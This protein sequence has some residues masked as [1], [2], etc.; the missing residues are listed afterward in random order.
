MLAQMKWLVLS[1]VL[2]GLAVSSGCVIYPR[3][4]DIG[5]FKQEAEKLRPGLDTHEQVLRHLGE[6]TSYSKKRLMYLVCDAPTGVAYFP[7]AP[8]QTGFTTVG[9]TCT[10][11]VLEFDERETLQDYQQKAWVESPQRPEEAA[12]LAAAEQ[13]DQDAQWQLY[14]SAGVLNQNLNWLCQAADAGHAA[15][16]YRV[17]LL[18]RYGWAGER[19]D[20]MLAY[21]WY[22][23]AAT[24]GHPEATAAAKRI[25]SEMKPEERSHAA[26]LLAAWKPG[27]CLEAGPTRD[28]MVFLAEQGDPDMNWALYQ[29][30][31]TLMQPYD[32]QYA[33]AIRWLCGAADAGHLK[34]QRHIGRLY[35]LGFGPLKRDTMRAYYWLRLPA[36]R[37]NDEYSWRRKQL[38]PDQIA[39]AERLTEE[40]QPGQC[41]QEL[42]DAL[43]PVE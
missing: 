5:E 3:A 15:A 36:S 6:P 2:A 28:H 26:D 42:A 22:M 18:Y 37:G 11:F 19:R 29:R 32:L 23:L 1:M 10:E 4:G 35:D 7:I 38:D 9:H 24:S 34:A 31:G 30:T 41:E 21:L 8:W 20:S 43:K 27:Q 16:R 13:G 17:G 40:W 33:A 39:E 25:R 14:A 12:T